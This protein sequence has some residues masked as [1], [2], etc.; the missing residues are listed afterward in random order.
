MWG[1]KSVAVILPTYREKRSIYNAIQQFDSS[2]YVDEI[3]V[4]DN[5]A[6]PGTEEQVL[7]TRAKLIKETKQ[8]FGRAIRTG[9]QHTKA[10]LLVIAEPDGTFDANDISK[11]L[12]YSN[13]FE[14]VFGSRTHIPLI[15]K[16]SQMTMVRRIMDVLLGKMIS[17]LF[18]CPPLSDVGCIFR[19]TSRKGWKKISH[20]CQ[21]DDAIFATQW[22]LAAAKNKV[23]FIEVPVNFRKRVGKSSLTATFRDQAWWG[24]RIFLYI[25]KVRFYG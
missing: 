7:M 16:H 22:Q 19:L 17:F 5:N 15:D 11:L 2:G 21:A 25:L 12:A 18:L 8:G 3:V 20:E 9:I 1:K 14:M 6:E 4:V 24:I 13:D 10:D 23:R